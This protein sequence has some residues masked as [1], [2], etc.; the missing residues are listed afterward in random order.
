MIG[1]VSLLNLVGQDLTIF[2]PEQDHFVKIVTFSSSRGADYECRSKETHYVCNE[3]RAKNPW[4]NLLGK[5]ED[6]KCNEYK[7]QCN[8]E[9]APG[10]VKCLIYGQAGCG[11]PDKHILCGEH[12]RLKDKVYECDGACVEKTE[13]CHG[14]CFP[15]YRDCEGTCVSVSDPSFKDCNGKCQPSTE[16]CEGECSPGFFKVVNGLSLIGRSGT[17]MTVTEHF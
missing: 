15:G 16:Q 1:I 10:Y 6:D 17:I 14:L 8:G 12:C 11:Q 7:E 3:S 5:H 13:Q 9:C 4:Q 2:Y